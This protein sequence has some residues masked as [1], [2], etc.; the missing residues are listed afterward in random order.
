MQREMMRKEKAKAKS[1][2]EMAPPRKT[3]PS[4]TTTGKSRQAFPIRYTA[5]NNA[6]KPRAGGRDTMLRACLR[7]NR[8]YL[9]RED[10]PAT[11]TKNL[12]LERLRQAI[13]GSMNPYGGGQGRTL[14]SKQT[15]VTST[16]TSGIFNNMYLRIPGHPGVVIPRPYAEE[17]DIHRF[18]RWFSTYLSLKYRV[19]G[20]Y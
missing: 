7:P 1:P 12:C 9:A 10:G 4:R 8:N 16:Q 15:T 19:G 18:L 5:G 11:T 13:E 3:K 2:Q 20:E 14:H 6:T 17:E